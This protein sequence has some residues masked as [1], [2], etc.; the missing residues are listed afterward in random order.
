MCIF[1]TILVAN[2]VA[3][4]WGELW[5]ATCILGV[6]LLS[7]SFLAVGPVKTCVVVW[8]IVRSRRD[9][10]DGA[11]A[12]ISSLNRQLDDLQRELELLKFEMEKLRRKACV[13]NISRN[14][15]AQTIRLLSPPE[16]RCW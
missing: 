13:N 2:I 3:L 12:Y 7:L 11:E 1:G 4:S 8:R 14:A 15:E 9:F 16:S 10:E 5:P 6:T